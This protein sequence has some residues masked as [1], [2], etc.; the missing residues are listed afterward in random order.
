VANQPL[1]DEYEAA[2]T[3]YSAMKAKI[4][5]AARARM[6]KADLNEM[7]RDLGRLK[8]RHDTLLKRVI[9]NNQKVRTTN[10]ARQ[11]RREELFIDVARRRLGEAAYHEVWAEVDRLER[12]QWQVTWSNE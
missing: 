3:A 4:K 7:N 12:E 1:L 9:A 6:P 8:R 11:Y 10:R 2:A 5:E